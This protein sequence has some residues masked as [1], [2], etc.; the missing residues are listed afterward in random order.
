MIGSLPPI[1]ELAR[2][3]GIELPEYLGEIAE[4]PTALDIETAPDDTT[5]ELNEGANNLA[6]G[7]AN[8]DESGDE[9][10]RPS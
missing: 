5:A 2:Q 3:A 9:G 1:H 7:N 8:S 4:K 6:A 10:Q